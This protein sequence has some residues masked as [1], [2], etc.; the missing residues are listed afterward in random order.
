MR[1]K[2]Q[3]KI[4]QFVATLLTDTGINIL[5]EN[6]L[7]STWRFV[8][9]FGLFLTAGL[10]T[11]M[12]S[13]TNTNNFYFFA[14]PSPYI[15]AATAILGGAYFLYHYSD[16]IGEI[17]HN[18]DANFYTYPDE[19]LI[20]IK[21]PWYLQENNINVMM[22]I[23]KYAI[24]N[25]LFM[26]CLPILGE[27]AYYGRIK[28]FIYPCWTPWKMDSLRIELITFFLE[29]LQ[30]CCGI[31]LNYTVS[32]FLLIIV[33]EFTR[34]YRRLI[35][36]VCSLESRTMVEKEGMNKRFEIALRENIVHCIRHHQ[37]LHK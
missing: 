26:V 6:D 14:N 10:S 21:Y 32:I 37:L 9:I 28:T 25:V 7:W 17:L 11:C 2:M 4:I 1:S 18:M 35:A 23:T 36:A 19:H 31:W 5:K 8:I 20:Q 24:F 27:L 15:A 34:Q 30:C 22:K 3:R 33:I 13:I 16:M 12:V 29:L